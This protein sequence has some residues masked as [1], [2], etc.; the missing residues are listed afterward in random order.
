MTEEDPQPIAHE[1]VPIFNEGDISTS[2]SVGGFSR[3]HEV[4]VTGDREWDPN[5]VASLRIEIGAKA[6]VSTLDFFAELQRIRPV[7]PP[8]A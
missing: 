1:L 8:Q 5:D 3:K 4:S 2:V 6:V 7:T